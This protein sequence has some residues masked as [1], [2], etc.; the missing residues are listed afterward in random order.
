[1][2]LFTGPAPARML[3]VGTGGASAEAGTSRLRLGAGDGWKEKW[4]GLGEHTRARDFFFFFSK[5]V[6]MSDWGRFV[7]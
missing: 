7:G 6:L 1:M 4:A 5:N 3:G 2:G